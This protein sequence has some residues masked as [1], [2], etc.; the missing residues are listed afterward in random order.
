MAFDWTEGFSP[1]PLP[2]LE[3]VEAA[4]KARSAWRPEP[5]SG[6]GGGGGEN[7]SGPTECQSGLNFFFSHFMNTTMVSRFICQI[8]V[9][10]TKNFKKIN[11]IRV[12]KI[13]KY[14]WSLLKS[15]F[16]DILDKNTAARKKN[17]DINIKI[18]SLSF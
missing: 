13:K 8:S 14:A 6:G 17:P 9:N 7:P 16:G 2:R 12:T 5:L 4:L 3:A 18:L 15:C 10:T 1:R 11:E